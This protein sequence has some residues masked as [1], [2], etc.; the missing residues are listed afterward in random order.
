[1]FKDQNMQEKRNK[2][3]LKSTEKTSILFFFVFAERGLLAVENT[4][5]YSN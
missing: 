5:K 3:N 2:K 4:Q 1:M